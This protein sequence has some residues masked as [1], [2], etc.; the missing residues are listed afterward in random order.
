LETTKQKRHA[1]RKEVLIRPE[2]KT[3]NGCGPQSLVSNV[4]W[5]SS[6]EDLFSHAFQETDSILVFGLKRI[7]RTR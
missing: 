7:P 3:K 5:S 6:S 1:G 4:A 2:A